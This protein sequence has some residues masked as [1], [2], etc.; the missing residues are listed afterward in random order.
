[1]CTTAQIK[2]ILFDGFEILDAAGPVEAFGMMPDD[3]GIEFYSLH[4]GMVKSTQSAKIETLPLSCANDKNDKNGGYVLLVPGGAGTRKLVED[5]HF[6]SSL[7]ACAEKASYVLSVCTGSALLA[8]AG[9]LDGFRAT[10]NKRAFD[11]ACSNGPA[12]DWVREARWV[13]DGRY[14]TSSGV[15][16]GIDMALGFIRDVHGEPSARTAAAR[17]EYIWNT[18][19]GNDPFA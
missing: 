16:A 6:I 7:R 17:M 1:M 19:S 11:W 9:L 14:Y 4:G 12:V 13:R 5:E 8:R 3:Y 2:V 18:D 15:S 10:S